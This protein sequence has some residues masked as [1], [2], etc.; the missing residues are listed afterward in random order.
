MDIAER[1]EEKFNEIYE[2]TFDQLEYRWNHDDDFS[3]KDL[4]RQLQTFYVDEG[5]DWA[6]RGLPGQVVK[7]ATIAAT[8]A[9]LERLR[10]SGRS[11]GRRDER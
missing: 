6:G 10:A 7:S 11:S 8:E 2:K 9:F 1:Q 5:N 4:E 3:V